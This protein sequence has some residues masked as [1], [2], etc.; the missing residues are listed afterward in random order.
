MKSQNEKVY[1]KENY[2]KNGTKTQNQWS[3]NRYTT[4]TQEPA[5]NESGIE[6]KKK[7]F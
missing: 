6:A 1:S 4:T 5:L 7:G 3:K 2:L